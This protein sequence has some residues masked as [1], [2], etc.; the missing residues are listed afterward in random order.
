[1]KLHCQFT[2]F[3]EGHSSCSKDL[4][5]LNMNSILILQLCVFSNVNYI[6]ISFIVSLT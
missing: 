6:E 3:V 5:Y 1:M 2:Q 4:T